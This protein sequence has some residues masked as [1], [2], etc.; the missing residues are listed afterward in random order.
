[1]KQVIAHNRTRIS[2]RA[3]DVFINA[4]LFQ[5]CW[6][7]AIFHFWPLMLIPLF[8]IL[9]HYYQSSTNCTRDFSIMSTVFLVG[10]MLDTL[11]LQLGVYQFPGHPPPDSVGALSLSTFLETVKGNFAPDWLIVLWAAFATTVTRSLGWL[12][13]QKQ[14]SYIV[15]ALGG[16]LAYVA[17]RACGALEFSNDDLGLMIAMWLAMTWLCRR[18]IED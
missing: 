18:L 17:G 12:F 14:L 15:M 8:T 5:A 10:V 13:E 11:L 16:P 1:M 3:R 7:L 4:M 9:G 2:A 6:L